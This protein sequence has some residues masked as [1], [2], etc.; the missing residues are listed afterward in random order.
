M[1]VRDKFKTQ[2]LLWIALLLIFASTNG[3]WATTCATDSIGKRNI[4]GKEFIVYLV[5]GGETVYGISSKFHVPI[6]ILMQHNPELVNGLKT[7]MILNIPY[8][9]KLIDDHKTTRKVHKVQPG[10]TLF[11]ISRKYKIPLNNLLKWNGM[12]LKAG[13]TIY[14]SSSSPQQEQ[15][16]DDL[17]TKES[18]V[19]KEEIDAVALKEDKPE[20]NKTDPKKDKTDPKKD[21]KPKE[22]SNPTKEA[23]EKSN[24]QK[25]VVVQNG[26][27][28]KPNPYWTD[29]L[30]PAPELG[31]KVKQRVMIIPYDPYL[32]FSDA[33]AEIAR[34]S[35]IQQTKVRQVFRRR[36]NAMLQPKGYETIHLLGGLLKDSLGD[37]N[38]IYK[39]VT[40]NY[41][42]I[43]DNGTS[44]EDNFTPSDHGKKKK[45]GFGI[46]F[47]DNLAG[48]H[49]KAPTQ[50]AR[51]HRDSR[52]FGVQI[53]D[54]RFYE[55]F[56]VKYGID[57]Y[58]FINQ[59]EV[60]TDYQTC[61]DRSSNKY[62]RN[63][64]THFSIFDSEGNQLAGNKITTYYH[65]NSNN[66]QK[67]VLD[68]MP[69]VA[70]QIMQQIPGPGGVK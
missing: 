33:D 46:K 18:E 28:I 6:D 7:A 31:P 24:P 40:Y 12:E 26:N 60:R 29:E 16:A 49:S 30:Q 45:K 48:S 36:L 17:N 69:Q 19:T 70:E 51:D 4:D 34:A 67:I 58:V 59:F 3:V 47:V 9:K 20:E 62:Q 2:K 15:P 13:Q 22:E 37:L 56:K 64:L 44:Q 10:E 61:L 14:V 50:D 25:Q 11:A 42:E 53:K 5:S 8:N 21:T 68:N 23:P 66:V 54:P 41:Q 32:Y 63:F 43:L 55:Y 39:S 27:G 57:I 65:S 52:Y 38:K 35:S 1:S